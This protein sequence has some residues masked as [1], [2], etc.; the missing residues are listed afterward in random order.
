MKIKGLRVLIFLI[1][2]VLISPAVVHSSDDVA[3][4]AQCAFSEKQNLETSGEGNVSETAIEYYS[5][6]C[7]GYGLFEVNLD[8]KQK[9]LF[10]SWSPECKNGSRSLVGNAPTKL[11]FYLC[12]REWA[13][14][15]Q[16]SGLM[17]IRFFDL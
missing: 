3:V 10:L 12:K 14:K 4:P 15:L 17:T 5:F 13:S 6:N 7:S 2:S 11:Q 1:L 9:D 8:Q 16:K